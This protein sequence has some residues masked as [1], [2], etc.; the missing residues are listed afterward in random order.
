MKKLDLIIDNISKKK[1]LNKN[2]VIIIHR[3]K[4][5]NDKFSKN[6]KILEEKKYG[7][8]KIFFATLN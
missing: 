1:I 3:H 7:I 4:K 2:G 6:L 5:E 8:S